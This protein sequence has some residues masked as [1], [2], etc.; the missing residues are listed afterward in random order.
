MEG[1]SRVTFGCSAQWGCYSGIFWGG[2]LRKGREGV[3]LFRG[4]VRFGR[5]GRRGRRRYGGLGSPR[6]KG[7]VLTQRRKSPQSFRISRRCVLPVI[8]DVGG[9]NYLE[10]R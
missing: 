4:A 5:A 10:G 8:V 7:E 9:W 6:Y 2:E 3:E 1:E